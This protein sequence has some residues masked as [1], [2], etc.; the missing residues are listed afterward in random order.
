VSYLAAEI[1]AMNDTLDAAIAD[2]ARR[3]HGLFGRHHLDQ[4]EVSEETSRHRLATGRWE[5]V[6]D[7]AYRVAGAPS[8]WR[9]TLLAACWA[10]GTRAVASHRS[11][12]A[13]FDL[14]G[15]RSDLTEIT[16]PR[17]RRARHDGLLVH[18]TRLLET[19]DITLVDAIPCT[20]IERTLFEIAGFGK[21]RTLD[22]AIDSALRRSLTCVDALEN[23][24][25]RVAKR[26]RPGSA[27][28]R[29]A[30]AARGPNDALP[31]SAPERLLAT[32]LM[33]QG[34]PM[35]QFQ[36]VVHDV[37]GA[38]VA[39]V[40]LAYPDW[41]ILI[42][43]DSY[44]EHVGKLALVRDSARRNALTAL[45]YTTLTATAADLRD[46]ATALA[47]VTR[48]VRARVA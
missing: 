9:A 35:P 3:H 48:R 14:P 11:A 46:D 25:A 24:A 45:G 27:R 5:L 30:V 20:T 28:F 34:L 36:Y 32:A 38:F 47:G 21:S 29:A 22:L 12:A 41:K 44:Q 6:H 40:D 26:G 33:R 19:A 18:E 39:R 1:T 8:S 16:C 31:D 15:G 4:L 23:T 2:V 37:S 10:G 7:S 13:L 43:Y 42:E 17:W